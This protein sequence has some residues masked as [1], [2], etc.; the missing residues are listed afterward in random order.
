MTLSRRSDLPGSHD[1]HMAASNIIRH[2]EIT[3][4]LSG[5]NPCCGCCSFLTS[6]KFCFKC[7]VF[8]DRFLSTDDINHLDL[9]L[10]IADVMRTCI[11]LLMYRQTPACKLLWSTLMHFGRRMD[12]YCTQRRVFFSGQ[13]ADAQYINTF[14]KGLLAAAQ[15]SRRCRE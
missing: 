11:Y 13:P 5:F 1:W 12:I 8:W 2:V 14:L 3:E 15:T 10:N 4:F 6:E 7:N 9:R